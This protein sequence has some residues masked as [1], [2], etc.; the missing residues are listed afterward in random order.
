MSIP[1]PGKKPMELEIPPSLIG[2]HVSLGFASFTENASSVW[3][4]I[5]K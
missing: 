2:N 3:S 5:T 4:N 1:F